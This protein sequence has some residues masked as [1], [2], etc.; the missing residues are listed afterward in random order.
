MTSLDLGPWIQDTGTR[1]PLTKDALFFLAHFRVRAGSP[2]NDDGD[3]PLTISGMTMR[4]RN[5]KG[6]KKE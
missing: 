6:I 5:K 4:E 1:D 3:S 2:L